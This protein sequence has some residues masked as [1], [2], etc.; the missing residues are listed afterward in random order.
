[1]F[2]VLFW[3]AKGCAIVGGLVL[4]ALIV[5]VCLSIM[6]K[7]TADLAHAMVEF[8]PALSGSILA[9]GIG[10]VRGDFELV[11]LGMAVTICLFLPLCQMTAGHARVDLFT[12]NMPV[13][14]LR[15]LQALVDVLV[16]AVLVVIVWKLFE[17]LEAK[18]RAGT[19]TTLLQ[20]PL[21]WAYLIGLSGLG[22]TA[23]CSLYTATVRFAEAV[24]G[25]SFLPVGE[26]AVH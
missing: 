25:R 10:P 4:S 2:R 7:I 17:G 13:T 26:G 9:L 16:A 15:V 24:S 5:M 23:L 22:L 3:L 20:I 11:E 6:G 12:Q 21:W 1:M 8:A 14:V 18:H 19:R